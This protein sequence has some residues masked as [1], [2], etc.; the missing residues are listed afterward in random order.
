MSSNGTDTLR[1]LAAEAA[2]FLAGRVRVTPLEPSPALSGRMGVPVDMKL[3]SLQVTGSFKLRGAWFAVHRLGDAARDGV[4]TCSAG[5]HGLGLAWAAREA[6]VPAR[7]YVPASVDTAKEAGLQALGAEVVK[8]PFDGFDDTE[9]WALERC[10]ADGMPYVSAYDDEAVMAGNGGALALE[11]LDQAPDA[12]TVVLPVGGGGMAAG[13][14]VP[15]LG[16]VPDG[17]V[18][19]A[20]LAS[21][22]ALVRSLEAGH[23]VTRMPHAETLAGGLEGG[24]GGLAFPLLQRAVTQVVTVDEGAVWDAVRWML[25]EHRLLIEPSAAVAVAACLSGEVQASGK[26][27]VVISGRNVSVRSLRRILTSNP[28]GSLRD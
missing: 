20:Q 12:A 7:V 23:A 15:F 8:S 22:P 9:E 25:D 13:L 19:A 27:I 1:E 18:V 14:S 4:A 26:T 24:L 10:R 6:G 28:D 3:E 16:S 17:I 5:N 11:I 2:S 21:C